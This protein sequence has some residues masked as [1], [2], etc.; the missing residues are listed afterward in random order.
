AGP[1]GGRQQRPPGQSQGQ[2]GARRP[3]SDGIS[4]S[5][6]E[7]KKRRERPPQNRPSATKAK[8][9]ARAEPRDALRPRRGIRLGRCRP[10]K[11]KSTPC[12]PCGRRS[13]KG[14]LPEIRPPASARFRPVQRR[15]RP[16]GGGLGSASLE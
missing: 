14:L 7:S 10:A 2:G 1:R 15:L 4:S 12:L 5:K 8:W 6:R 11:S 9:R 3:P 16:L 13:T